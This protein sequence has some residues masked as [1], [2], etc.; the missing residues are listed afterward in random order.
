LRQKERTSMIEVLACFEGNGCRP[1]H[2][3]SGLRVGGA[4]MFTLNSTEVHGVIIKK[5]K[6]RKSKNELPKQT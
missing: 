4:G 2:R 1:S 5:V 3:G 6:D